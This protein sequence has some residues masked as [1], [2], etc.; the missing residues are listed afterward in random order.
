MN[1]GGG[2][3]HEPVV[4]Q[5]RR[6]RRRMR[7]A[8]TRRRSVYE[9]RDPL[10]SP[11]T[12]TNRRR[13]GGGSGSSIREAASGVDVRTGTTRSDRSS[14]WADDRRSRRLCGRG[15]DAMRRRQRAITSRGAS[16]TSR[17]RASSW[18]ELSPG[19]S[20]AEMCSDLCRWRRSRRQRNAASRL[21]R[22]LP[23]CS[24]SPRTTEILVPPPAEVRKASARPTPLSPARRV[25]ARPPLVCRCSRARRPNGCDSEGQPSRARPPRR[26]LSGAAARS[27]RTRSVRDL[28]T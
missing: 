23:T 15:A 28:R 14:G 26:R 4:G 5:D 6:E 2:S 3:S 10:P 19:R 8:D 24:T 1:G 13:A 12:P 21:Q 27:T 20:L 11:A 17:G 9:D 18:G 7:P 22:P 16:C 25:A